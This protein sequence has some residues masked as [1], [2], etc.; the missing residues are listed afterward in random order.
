ML[1]HTQT[2]SVRAR[3]P[4]QKITRSGRISLAKLP[5]QPGPGKRPVA[6]GSPAH[7]AQ[8][9]CGL[10]EREPGKEPKLDE[11][12]AA[13]VDPGQSAKGF[14]QVDKIIGRPVVGHECVEIDRPPLP[15]ATALEPFAIAGTIQQDPPHRL[16]RRREKV[17]ATLPALALIRAD[18]SQ[19]GLMHE[20]RRL[21][22][23]TGLLV[24]QTPRRQPPELV[25]HQWQ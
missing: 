2:C 8:S 10:V 3:N 18:D 7:D 24:C 19:I 21:E 25:V 13:G 5:E 4:T 22:S 23:L 9:H 16:G 6:L 20:R 17:P 15:A 12:G 1:V 14:I 11:L